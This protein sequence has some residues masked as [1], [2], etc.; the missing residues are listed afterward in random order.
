MHPVPHIN[1]NATETDR[2]HD[3]VNRM[4]VRPRARTT[5]YLVVVLLMALHGIKV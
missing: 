1:G 3:D 4:Y 2:A 5:T